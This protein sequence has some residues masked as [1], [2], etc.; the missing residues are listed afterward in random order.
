M[1]DDLPKEYS[2][3]VTAAALRVAVIFDSGCDRCDADDLE[4]LE[5]AGL[6]ETSICRDTFG[7]DSLEAGDTMWSFN[8]EGEALIAT[9]PVNG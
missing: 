8:A 7:Q 2:P 9:L 6:M 5:K 1:E 4:V 3:E